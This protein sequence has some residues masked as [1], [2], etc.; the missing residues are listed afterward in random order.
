MPVSHGIGATL[1]GIGINANANYFKFQVTKANQC[2]FLRYDIDGHYVSH[3]DTFV[4]A[5]FAECRKL[6]V[7][8]ILNDDFEGG[9]FYI[10]DGDKKT[11]PPQKAGT[12]L[13]FPSFLLH[14]V[15][16]VTSGIRRTIVTWLVGDWFK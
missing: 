10:Q 12:V 1:T 13:I 15:E 16:P 5:E 9:K 2:D 14:G 4:D 3:V 11:Y 8:L 6:T 7:L